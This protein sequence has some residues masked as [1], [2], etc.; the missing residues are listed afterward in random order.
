MPKN[1]LVTAITFLGPVLSL[2]LPTKMPNRPIR[3]KAVEEAPEITALD[4]PNSESKGLKNTPYEIYV[5][6]P[7]AWMLKQLAAMT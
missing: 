6:I 3:K 5:P 1:K 4:K 2:S 7:I